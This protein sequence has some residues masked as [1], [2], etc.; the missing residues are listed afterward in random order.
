MSNQIPINQA[1][2]FNFSGFYATN[3]YEINIFQDLNNLNN[4]MMINSDET[5]CC[6]SNR[7]ISNNQE[8]LYNLNSNSWINDWGNLE[9]FAKPTTYPQFNDHRVTVQEEIS[10]LAK[11]ERCEKAI[12][13][14]DRHIA[15]NDH[16]SPAHSDEDC[17]FTAIVTPLLPFIKKFDHLQI[18]T[19]KLQK[20]TL[21]TE[22][23]K[24][25]KENLKTAKK[26]IQHV[27]RVIP[28]SH[29]YLQRSR[30]FTSNL[31][32]ANHRLQYEKIID[33][34]STERRKELPFTTEQIAEK[35]IEYKNGNCGPMSREGFLYAKT[36]HVPI[37]LVRINPDYG[38]HMFLV[39]GR[40]TPC[41]VI[42]DVWTG[43]YFPASKI[44]YLMDHVG[45]VKI[46][47]MQHTVVQHYDPLTQPLQVI[48]RN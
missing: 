34:A 38:D 45:P 2:D 46:N 22:A 18:L 21:L 31:E 7:L 42:C 17:Y 47:G 24:E 10:A 1:P 8:T 35:A 29:N 28:F 48:A 25:L 9:S 36:L 16:P 33:N 4:D 39:I 15:A 41:K 20:H 27:D 40:N 14:I 32:D 37:D 43:A 11:I 6:L 13:E 44:E 12:E 30:I 26:I 19:G 5:S 3:N 23:D